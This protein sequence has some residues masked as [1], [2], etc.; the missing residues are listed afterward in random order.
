MAGESRP[1]RHRL[2]TALQPAYAS[3]SVGID[4]EVADVTG[5]AVMAWVDVAIED[6]AGR[7]A[8]ADAEIYEVTE[9]AMVT[10]EDL[11]DAQGGCVDV[12]GDPAGSPQGGVEAGH[13]VEGVVADPEVDRV[14]DQAG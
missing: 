3:R 5:E 7:D 9:A 12:V 14:P 6:H 4:A 1:R 10:T 8:R 2:E 11:V 13:D